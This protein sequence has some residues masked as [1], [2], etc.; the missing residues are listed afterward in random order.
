VWCPELGLVCPQVSLREHWM[1][2]DEISYEHPAIRR[3]RSIAFQQHGGYKNLR[4]GS[5]ARCTVLKRY[6]L[7][8]L[9]NK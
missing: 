1:N 7:T 9:G 3:D 2:F 4:G 8:G 6:T 5:D